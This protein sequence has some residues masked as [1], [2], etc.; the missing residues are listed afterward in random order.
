[1]YRIERDD[2]NFLMET[3]PIVKR[4]DEKEFGEYLTKR[5]ILEMDD[6]MK[7][8]GDRRAIPDEIGTVACR[9]VGGAF[10]ER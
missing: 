4:K 6:E 8:D 1:M 10:A 3:F 5:V 7:R 2:V 9:S